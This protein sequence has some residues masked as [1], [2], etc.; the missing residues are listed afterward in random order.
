MTIAELRPYQDK[1][2]ILGLADGEI[3]TG[4]IV[5]VDAE[6]EDIIVDIVSTNRPDNYRD[7][8]SAYTI[9]AIDLI[10][11]EEVSGNL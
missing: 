4:K 9:A 6:Y 1:T 11:V 10:S 2:V 5:F 8:D 3:T 7:S